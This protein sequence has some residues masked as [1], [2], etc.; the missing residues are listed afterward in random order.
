[1]IT[2]P[3]DHPAFDLLKNG[4]PVVF[5]TDDSTLFGDQSSELAVAAYLLDLSSI[6]IQSMQAEAEKHVFASPAMLDY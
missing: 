1:M 4:H 3:A 2:S 5:C 6:Q